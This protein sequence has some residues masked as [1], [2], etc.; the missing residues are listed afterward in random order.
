MNIKKQFFWIAICSRK[1]VS[2]FLSPWNLL[3]GFLSNTHSRTH[4]HVDSPSCCHLISHSIFLAQTIPLV[5]LQANKAAMWTIN[6]T[7]DFKKLISILIIF[8]LVLKLFAAQCSHWI[9]KVSEKTTTTNLTKTHRK[10]D[11]P[12]NG[13]KDRSNIPREYNCIQA[14]SIVVVC[15]SVYMEIIMLRFTL[16]IN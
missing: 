7:E 16:Q 10:K 11:Q 8:Y 12:K 2:T 14:L 3:R 4:T 13:K 1:I 15:I 6:W 5:L 9:K